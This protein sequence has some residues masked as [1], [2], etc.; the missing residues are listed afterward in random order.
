MPNTFFEHVASAAS[1]MDVLRHDDWPGPERISVA[2]PL[3]VL[4]PNA[5]G[6]FEGASCQGHAVRM[7]YMLINIPSSF[8]TATRLSSWCVPASPRTAR[9]NS[10]ISRGQ[11]SLTHECK[12]ALL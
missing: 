1:V 5:S 7:P 2:K 10:W 4:F 12:A 8:F 6:R 3:A 11:G 9:T